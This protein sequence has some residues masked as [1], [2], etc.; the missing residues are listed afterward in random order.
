[1]SN[2]APKAGGKRAESAEQAKERTTSRE[3]TIRVLIFLIGLHVFAG[4]VMLLFF[5]G[6]H[7]H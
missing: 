6:D 7:H 5:V 3:V 1:M 2:S 4:F